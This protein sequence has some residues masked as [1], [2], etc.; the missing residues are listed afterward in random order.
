M[1]PERSTYKAFHLDYSQPKP[2]KPEY[3]FFLN[4]GKYNLY[5]PFSEGKYIDTSVVAVSRNKAW[6]QSTRLKADFLKLYKPA[7][8]DNLLVCNS[9]IIKLIGLSI[10]LQQFV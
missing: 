9:T 5:I 7:Q 10:L 6:S 3:Y 8:D 1:Y 2:T 4:T